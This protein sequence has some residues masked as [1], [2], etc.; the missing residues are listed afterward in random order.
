MS[1]WPWP[2]ASW[3]QVAKKWDRTRG[4]GKLVMGMTCQQPR[5]RQYTETISKTLLW[6]QSDNV[7]FN[8][9][10][11]NAIGFL[12]GWARI[13]D[14]KPCRAFSDTAFHCSMCAIVSWP[15]ARSAWGVGDMPDG[16][17]L[18]CVHWALYCSVCPHLVE[19][20]SFPT[21]DWTVLALQTM[22][23]FLI[24]INVK[25]CY[26]LYFSWPILCLG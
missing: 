4:L 18:L 12:I 22:F 25:P 1:L 13:S 16:Q 15:L 10:H 6:D 19:W 2:A 5:S 24:L 7:I 11:D 20:T 14:Y 23:L 21:F 26:H 8:S 3:R 17:Y 9:S